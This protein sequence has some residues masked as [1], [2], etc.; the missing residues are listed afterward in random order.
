[1]TWPDTIILMLIFF[2]YFFSL[3]PYKFC[4]CQHETFCGQCRPFDPPDLDKCPQFQGLLK[5]VLD[6]LASSDSTIL[7]YHSVFERFREYRRL[8]DNNYDSSI[9]HIRDILVNAPKF[10]PLSM[11]WTNNY[12]ST[13]W[14]MVSTAGRVVPDIQINGNLIRA[15]EE[16]PEV[17][18]LFDTY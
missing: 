17:Y 7:L 15:F 18:K 6:H 16:V 1:M 4:L 3:G 14:G 10:N 5:Q 9:P 11:N 8:D 2:L 13:C 12:Y